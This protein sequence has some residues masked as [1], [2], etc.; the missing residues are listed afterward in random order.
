MLF[1]HT[2]F[3]MKYPVDSSGVPARYANS[4]CGVLDRS[5]SALEW[6]P[7]AGALSKDVGP[8]VVLWTD[9]GHGPVRRELLPDGPVLAVRD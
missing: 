7:S 9:S 8:T 4:G 2:H 6:D 5:F 3:P 1:G